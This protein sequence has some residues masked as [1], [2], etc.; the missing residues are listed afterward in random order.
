MTQK[1]STDSPQLEHFFTAYAKNFFSIREAPLETYDDQLQKKQPHQHRG[2]HLQDPNSPLGNPILAR[3][4]QTAQKIH[5]MFI[6]FENNPTLKG[7][8]LALVRKEPQL[9]YVLHVK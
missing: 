5:G 8:K 9:I 3:R 2:Y 6:D 1:Y 7:R 4:P